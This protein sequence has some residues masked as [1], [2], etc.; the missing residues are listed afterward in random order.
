MKLI[1]KIILIFIYIFIGHS[2]LEMDKS[3]AEHNIKNK[4]KLMVIGR[5]VSYVPVLCGSV[6]DW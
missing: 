3:L 6:I 2:L 4:S 1:K 5:K